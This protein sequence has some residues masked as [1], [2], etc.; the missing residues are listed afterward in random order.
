M[1]KYVFFRILSIAN[2]IIIHRKFKLMNQEYNH[3]MKRTNH[4]N[5]EEQKDVTHEKLITS[6]LI[7]TP[8]SFTD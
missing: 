3:Y 5:S 8:I 6:Q 1:A 7:P 2:H 4:W